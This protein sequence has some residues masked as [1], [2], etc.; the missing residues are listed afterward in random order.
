MMARAATGKMTPKEAMQWAARALEDY[1]KGSPAG[2]EN[3][4][5]TARWEPCWPALL[6]LGG[7][8]PRCEAQVPV[9][10]GELRIVVSVPI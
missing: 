10:R 5:N 7:L 9:P 6:L 3:H 1:V 8:A 2:R 4:V